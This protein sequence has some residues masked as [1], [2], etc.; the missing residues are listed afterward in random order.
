MFITLY[1]IFTCVSGIYLGVKT[2]SY[3]PPL[4]CAKKLYLIQKPI[5]QCPLTILPPEQVGVLLS[6][7]WSV[8][9]TFCVY[10]TKY[11]YQ[12]KL[13]KLHKRLIDTVFSRVWD[14]KNAFLVEF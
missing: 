13:L 9:H 12:E 7:S 14:I 10:Y 2:N 11:Q 8:Q 6:G 4:S 1:V 3:S 5:L